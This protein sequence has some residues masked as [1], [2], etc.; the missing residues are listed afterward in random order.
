MKI[1]IVSDGT[2]QGSK[3]VNAETGEVLGDVTKIEWKIQTGD[4][5]RISI[6]LNF[7]IAGLEAEVE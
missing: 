5:A 6:E 7:P 1:K 3:V 2:P 4:A